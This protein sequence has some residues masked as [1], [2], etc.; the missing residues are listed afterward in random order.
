MQPF[1]LV[2]HAVAAVA[3][4]GL[5]LSS[6]LAATSPLLAGADGTI[7]VIEAPHHGDPG[8][9]WTFSPEGTGR[10][11]LP[12]QPRYPAEW[13]PDGRWL[14]FACRA[15]L[16]RSGPDGARPQV[17]LRT[18]GLRSFD[19]APDGSA[20][21]VVAHDG[22]DILSVPAAGGRPALFVR[23]QGLRASVVRVSPDGARLALIRNVGADGVY[24]SGWI[25]VATPRRASKVDC[26]A[27]ITDYASRPSW[28]ADGRT[29]VFSGPRG[30][31][32]AA[33]PNPPSWIHR[34]TPAARRVERLRRGREPVM[35][36][37]GTAM[38]FSGDAGTGW[39]ALYVAGTPDAAARRLGTGGSLKSWAPSGDALAYLAAGGVA[40]VSTQDGGS[41]LVFRELFNDPYSI[42]WSRRAP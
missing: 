20:L 7:L 18:S 35:A 23:L 21:V 9:W 27:R 25:C 19:W 30:R 13:S 14:A 28:S 26:V 1:R 38:A 15:G 31:S 36:P 16:C 41:R 37:V 17:V 29:F 42:S 33:R 22:R 32:T 8:G 3:V 12:G 40:V 4:A 39:D 11:A 2:L 5:A 6:G 24:T 10:R 34:V